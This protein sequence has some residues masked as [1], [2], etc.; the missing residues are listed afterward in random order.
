MPAKKKPAEKAA[1][2]VKAAGKAAVISSLKGTATSPLDE[3]QLSKAVAA[4]SAYAEKKR[5]KRT[6]LLT[7]DDAEP[8][9]V[10]VATH[11]VADEKKINP[12]RV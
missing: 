12:Y 1:S 4:L 2:A 6:N 5:S 7:Q 9:S 8:I 10:I 3:A 11:K